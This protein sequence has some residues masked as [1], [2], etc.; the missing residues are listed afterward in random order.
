VMPSRADSLRWMVTLFDPTSLGRSQS[1]NIAAPASAAAAITDSIARLAT[2]ALWQ[3]DHT[4]R[5][6]ATPTPTPP[7]KP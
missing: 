4:P 5:R 6:N 1:V 7:S 2:N 3:L